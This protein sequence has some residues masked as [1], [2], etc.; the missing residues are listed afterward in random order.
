MN[1]YDWRRDYGNAPFDITQWLVATCIYSLPALP[2]TKSFVKAA[3]GWWQIN[4]ITTMQSGTPFKLSMNT[5]SAN[6]SSQGSQRK[7]FPWT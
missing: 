5:D 6:T 4:G 1:P 3:F 2:H 7:F